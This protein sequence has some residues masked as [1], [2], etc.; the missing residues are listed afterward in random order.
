MS[1]LAEAAEGF[2]LR[3]AGFVGRLAKHGLLERGD[4]GRVTKPPESACRLLADKRAGGAE[5]DGQGGHGAAITGP[6]EERGGIL[7]QGPVAIAQQDLTGQACGRPAVDLEEQI[8]GGAAAVITSPRVAHQSDKRNLGG[9]P[10]LAQRPSRGVNH[11]KVLIGQGGHE[12]YDASFIPDPVERLG[13]LRSNPAVVVPQ[14]PEQARDRSRAPEDPQR[15][16]R[17]G[18]H[19][20]IRVSQAA[21]DGTHGAPVA[22]AR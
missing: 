12:G 20:P 3:G 22:T 8:E 16:G 1:R 13:G 6:A 19:L 5:G 14:G 10:H 2:E 21:C 15:P 4:C 7:V 11:F 17:V 9:G 18:P